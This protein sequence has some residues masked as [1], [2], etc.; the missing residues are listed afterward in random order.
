MGMGFVVTW[1]W[2]RGLPGSSGRRRA[3]AE[4]HAWTAHWA[5]HPS[6]V[7]GRSLGQFI[8]HHHEQHA[9]MGGCIRITLSSWT[10]VAIRMHVHYS[11]TP[12]SMKPSS[13]ILHFFRLLLRITEYGV[14]STPL[15]HLLNYYLR[16]TS[17]CGL[18]LS[19]LTHVRVSIVVLVSHQQYASLSS[20]KKST[21]RF[22]CST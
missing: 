12:T 19:L 17:V 1:P 14:R 13:R 16:I 5:A 9:R 15:S 22:T 3:R 8:N 21:V 7:V 6:V 20:K 18:C 11:G 2:R 4:S 10:V